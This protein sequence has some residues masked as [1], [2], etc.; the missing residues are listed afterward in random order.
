MPDY[1]ENS[2]WIVFALAGLHHRAAS[3]HTSAD[4]GAPDASSG[5]AG[6]K[7]IDLSVGLYHPFPV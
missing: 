1:S 5:C 4:D 7:R 3:Y 6:R 2:I